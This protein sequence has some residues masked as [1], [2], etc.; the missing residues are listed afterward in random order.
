MLFHDTVP[1][2]YNM[3]QILQMAIPLL[4][5]KGKLRL[6]ILSVNKPNIYVFS[7]HCSPYRTISGIVI[8]AAEIMY[9]RIAKQFFLQLGHLVRYEENIPQLLVPLYSFKLQHMGNFKH[10]IN[11]YV[12]GTQC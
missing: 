4:N 10:N 6:H 8:T 9:S 3:F 7:S 5:R 12:L 2:L 1:Y 11:R